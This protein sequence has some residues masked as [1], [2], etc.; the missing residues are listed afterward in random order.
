MV[1]RIS[2][3]AMGGFESKEPTVKMDG[4]W[5]GYHGSRGT[6]ALRGV[7]LTMSPGECI[8]V[9]GRNGAGKTTLVKHLNGLLKPDRG[10][11]NVLGQN[12]LQTP[13]AEL[14]RHV[15]FAWQMRFAQFESQLS[16]SGA[17][18][19]HTSCAHD[20][21]VAGFEQYIPNSQSPAL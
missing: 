8:A 20:G 14:A 13:V 12:T 18:T 3:G 21:S 9:V 10:E 16:M 2:K 6:P 11:V 7:S 19:E 1:E 4:V 15:G 5:F 17:P